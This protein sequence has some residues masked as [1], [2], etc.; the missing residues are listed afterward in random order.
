MSDLR[1]FKQNIQGS[2]CPPFIAT[3][4]KLDNVNLFVLGDSY[5]EFLNSTHFT[6]NQYKNISVYH[7]W[8]I[9]PLDTTKKNVL[10]FENTERHMW[11]LFKQPASDN[12]ILEDPFFPTR[13]KWTDYIFNI[14]AESNLSYMLTYNSFICFFKEIKSWINLNIFNRVDKSVSLSTDRHHI[15]LKETTDSTLI[16]SAFYSLSDKQIDTMVANINV[17]YHHFRSLGFNNVYLSIIP[18]PV[19]LIEP[20]EGNYNHLI[21]RIES[22]PKLEMPVIDIYS[23]YKAS[24]TSYYYK[25]DPH[26]NCDGRTVWLQKV[27][28]ILYTISK[29]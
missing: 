14:K 3:H 16:T 24:P 23:V 6:A 22:S 12:I 28:S 10:I 11:K 26:W 25:S 27:D 4:P 21:E 8:V 13:K 5:S 9:P 20:G 18:N 1:Q 29:K 7:P 2:Y 15:F 19:S 17:V